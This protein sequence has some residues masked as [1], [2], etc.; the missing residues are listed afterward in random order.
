MEE[1]EKRGSSA[2]THAHTRTMVMLVIIFLLNIILTH[3]NSHGAHL[4]T[5]VWLPA[6]HLMATRLLAEQEILHL[7]IS[8]NTYFHLW[9]V[10]LSLGQAMCSALGSSAVNDKYGSHPDGAQGLPDTETQSR[11]YKGDED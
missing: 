9:T 10:I 4:R 11:N 5:Q 7:L 3:E 1:D 2:R 8:F 6:P